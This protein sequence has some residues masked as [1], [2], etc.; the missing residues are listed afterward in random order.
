[1][2]SLCV[3]VCF[4]LNIKL[5]SVILSGHRGALYLL[6]SDLTLVQQLSINGPY[7]ITLVC[8]CLVNV[9]LFNSMYMVVHSFLLN[10]QSLCISFPYIL[11]LSFSSS[12]PP[13]SLSPHPSLGTDMSLQPGTSVL[14]SL[15]Q[16][17]HSGGVCKCRTS[18]LTG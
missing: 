3:C 15:C 14:S 13:P 8:Y 17:Y 10:I 5:C 12:T 6:S 2:H 18:V 4:F 9:Y 7:C 1:M 11:S 16:L